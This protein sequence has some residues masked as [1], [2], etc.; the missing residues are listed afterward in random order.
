MEIAVGVTRHQLPLSREA[1]I[2]L[3]DTQSAPVRHVRR[4]E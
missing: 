3:N 2:A 4:K 1:H